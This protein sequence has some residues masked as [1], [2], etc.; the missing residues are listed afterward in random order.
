MGG[1]A[2][3]VA[4]EDVDEVEVVATEDE[5]DEANEKVDSGFVF[6]F[7]FFLTLRGQLL[8][9]SLQNCEE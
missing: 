2:R 6:F 1:F 4:L 5:E 3:T 8:L 7:S 9:K